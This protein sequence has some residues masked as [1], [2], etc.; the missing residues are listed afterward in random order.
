MRIKFDA[1]S[2]PSVCHKMHQIAPN[3]VSNKKKFPG[4]NTPDPY[5]GEGDTPSPKPLFRLGASRLDSWPSATR[6]KYRH[7][8]ISNLSTGY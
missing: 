5:P 4:D 2:L 8:F 1:Y 6:C 7:F 3:Y